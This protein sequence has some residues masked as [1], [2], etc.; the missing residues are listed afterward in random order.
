V[1][2][3]TGQDVGGV[4]PV[5]HPKPLRTVVDAD[6]AA[7]PLLW[8]GGGD[9]HTMFSATYEELLRMTGGVAAAIA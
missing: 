5:G 6:L 2:E 3:A 9:R 1:L 7:H 4:A 8:A